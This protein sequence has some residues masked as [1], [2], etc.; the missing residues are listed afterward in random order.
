VKD[1]FFFMPRFVRDLSENGKEILSMNEIVAYLLKSYQPVV[2]EMDLMQVK[3]L[4]V[5]VIVF[6]S[7]S[8]YKTI[9]NF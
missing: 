1:R 9:R 5:I 2:D 6:E 4:S 3:K 7:F 8:S